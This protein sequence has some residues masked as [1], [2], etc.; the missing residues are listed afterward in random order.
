V[1]IFIN[2]GARPWQLLL[3]NEL[4]QAKPSSYKGLVA[5]DKENYYTLVPVNKLL[6]KK[7]EA[8]QTLFG[9]VGLALNDKQGRTV[10]TVSLLNK[11]IVYLGTTDNTERFLAANIFAA[12][13]L[14]EQIGG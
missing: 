6:N 5:L 7:G 3:D 8:K 12:L 13:L 2:E 1:Q 14:Q 11:G 4:M 9:S 10:A